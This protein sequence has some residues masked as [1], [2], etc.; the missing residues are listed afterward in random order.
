MKAL[1][2]IVGSD[3]RVELMLIEDGEELLIGLVEMIDFTP[4]HIF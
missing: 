4:C 3:V 1:A 2:I